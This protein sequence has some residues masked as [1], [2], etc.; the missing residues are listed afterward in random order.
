MSS[1]PPESQPLRVAILTVS[2]AA[3]RGQRTDETGPTLKRLVE[4]SGMQVVAAEVV[5]DER[6]DIASRITRLA[7]EAE[8]IFTCGGTG[9]GPRDVTPEATLEV[10]R[11][12]VPGLAEAL[13]AAGLPH[14]PYAMLSRA[15]AGVIGST[16]V[17]N[18]PGSPKAVQ[19]QY[20]VVAPVLAH[21]VALLHGHTEH[22]PDEKRPA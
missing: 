3:S 20:P 6:D 4:A 16:L 13:R 5:A 21:A 1:S 18:L 14:T 17:I 15:V 2:D 11:Y 7:D 12:Q 9:L 10:I 8:V 22:K 19:E